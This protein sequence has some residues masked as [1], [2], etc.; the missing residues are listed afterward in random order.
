MTN[1]QEALDWYSRKKEE[2]YINMENMFE[3]GHPGNDFVKSIVGTQT[4]GGVVRTSN[5]TLAQDIVKSL[6]Y[7]ERVNSIHIKYESICK[8]PNF[9]TTWIITWEE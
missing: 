9:D 5:A 7:R 3:T 4:Y 6:M 8:Y 2:V 1:P